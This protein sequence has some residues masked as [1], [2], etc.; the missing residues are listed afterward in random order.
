MI[1]KAC[2]TIAVGQQVLAAKGYK[3]DT[4]L[5]LA[6]VEELGSYYV[7]IR[8]ESSNAKVQR[9]PNDLCVLEY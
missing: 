7:V 3:G 5:Y 4:E 6:T 8:F 2:K 1:D 9:V